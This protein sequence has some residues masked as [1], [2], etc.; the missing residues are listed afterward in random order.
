M[1]R[2]RAR[3]TLIEQLGRRPVDHVI[4]AG[5]AGG[6]SPQ[7]AAGD[8]IEPA[9]VVDAATG[10][11]WQVPGSTGDQVLLTGDHVIESP[12]QKQQ[13]RDR[14][15]ADLVDMETA[16][17]A[18]GCVGAGVGWTV[19]RGISD[20][21]DQSLPPGVVDIVD[22]QGRP[23]LSALAAF[24]IRRPWQIPE[25]IRLGRRSTRTAVLLAQSI[26]AWLA[27]RQGSPPL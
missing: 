1:G 26:E 13:W 17:I 16:A 14:Y 24:L 27:K 8:I 23:C 5:L 6:L 7:L 9:R 15:S 19:I 20:A 4:V 3:A 11:Q 21:A 2:D 18:E 12:A 22:A 25:L 10:Q